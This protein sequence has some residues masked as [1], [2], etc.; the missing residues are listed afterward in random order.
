[1]TA[2]IPKMAVGSIHIAPAKDRPKLFLFRAEMPPAT[3]IAPKTRISIP[4]IIIIAGITPATISLPGNH[5]ISGIN[6][7]GPPIIYYP[8][9]N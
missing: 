6:Q 7:N 4:T 9:S 3:P 5:G 8:S 1:M 2:S